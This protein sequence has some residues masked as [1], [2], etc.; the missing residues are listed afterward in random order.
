MIDFLITLVAW[1]PSEFASFLLASLPLTESR[2][3]LPV[4]LFVFGLSPLVA[5][6]CTFLGNLLP[7]PILFSL[8]PRLVAFI[9]SHNQT[10]N[11][12]I[13]CWFDSLRR[14]HTGGYSKWGALFLLIF[15]AIPWPGTGVWTASVLAILFQIRPR[16]AVVAIIVGQIIGSIAVTSISLGIFEGVK[17]L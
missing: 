12:W 13:N 9:E 2:L 11:R 16:L 8:L 5:F 3:A 17:L 6:V 15:V 1:M 14:K 10:L 7:I 4:A